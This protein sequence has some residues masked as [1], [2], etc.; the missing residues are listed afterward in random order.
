MAGRAVVGD[1]EVDCAE[2]LGGLLKSYS[3]A[4]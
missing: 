3:H 4:A 2:R 1:A